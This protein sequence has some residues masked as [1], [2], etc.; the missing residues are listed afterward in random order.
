MQQEQQQASEQQQQMQMMEM[1]KSASGPVAREAAGA[2]RQAVVGN[3][4]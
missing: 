4:E 1:A 2:V 3:G